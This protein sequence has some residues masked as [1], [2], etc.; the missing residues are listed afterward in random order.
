MTTFIF[1]N[2][3]A[4]SIIAKMLLRSLKVFQEALM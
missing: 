1:T 4:L 3:K 2:F